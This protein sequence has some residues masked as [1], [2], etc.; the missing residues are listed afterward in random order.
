MILHRNL[1]QLRSV[2]EEVK[3]TALELSD[4]AVVEVFAVAEGELY[5]LLHPGFITTVVS[6]VI[7]SGY[8]ASGFKTRVMAAFRNLRIAEVEM[9]PRITKPTIVGTI[10][11]IHLLLR[12]HPRS[13][14][15]RALVWPL[16][17]VT[18]DLPALGSLLL[19]TGPF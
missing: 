19:I 6:L 3:L 1:M 16:G 10:G 13:L 7:L 5:F 15:I 8:V 17:M 12:P 18:T 9:V 4:E 2:G 14:F 11:S